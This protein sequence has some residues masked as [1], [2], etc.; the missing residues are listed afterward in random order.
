MLIWVAERNGYRCVTE[1]A[2]GPQD[3]DTFMADQVEFEN[4][5][6]RLQLKASRGLAE[7]LFAKGWRAL[8]I[9]QFGTKRPGGAPTEVFL[10]LLV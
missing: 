8:G 1:S 2:N 5:L 10:P 6:I 3:G 4:E 7:A 9:D